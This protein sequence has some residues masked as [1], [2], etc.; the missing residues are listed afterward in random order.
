MGSVG[1]I[2]G[3]DGPTAIFVTAKIGSG[4]NPWLILAGAAAVVVVGII[5]WDIRK[6]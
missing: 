6:K 3:A 4:I 2:G 1:V 5:L